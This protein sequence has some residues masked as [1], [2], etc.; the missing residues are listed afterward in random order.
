MEILSLNNFSKYN[1]LV[2][3]FDENKNKPYEEWLEFDKILDKP[4][5]QGIV[6]L[7]KNK[8]N[9]EHKYIFKISQYINYLVYHELII[10]HG[11]KEISTYCPHFCKGIGMINCKVDAKYRKNCDNPFDTINKYQIDKDVLLCEYIEDSCKFY[12]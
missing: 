11:L 5:K 7:F 10:M 12:N 8:K 2:K 3:Y 1:E 4:G 9:S 6:G